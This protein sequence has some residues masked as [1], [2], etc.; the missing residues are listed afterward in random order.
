MDDGLTSVSTETEAIKLLHETKEICAQGNLRLHKIVSNKLS[1]TESV[2][3]E[4]RLRDSTHIDFHD[5]ASPPEKALG[6][7]T[8]N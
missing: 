2:P 1:V 3:P 6:V 4:D 8:T 5:T 7:H